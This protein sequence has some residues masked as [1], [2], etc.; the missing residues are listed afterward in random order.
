M[1]NH[2][3][4]MLSLLLLPAMTLA[5]G[6]G[7]IAETTGSVSASTPTKTPRPTFTPDARVAQAAASPTVTATLTPSPTIEIPTATPPPPPSDTP[8]VPP[9]PTL[10]PTFTPT[11]EPTATPMLFTPTP[12]AIFVEPDEPDIAKY[13]FKIKQQGIIPVNENGGKGPTALTNVFIEVEDSMQ[14]PLNGIV[15]QDTLSGEEVVTGGDK[16]DGRAEILMQGRTLVIK[17]V[18]DANTGRTYASEETHRLSVAEPELEDLVAPGYCESVETCE[19]NPY[20]W[21]FSYRIVFQRQW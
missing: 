10:E 5:S 6:C 15:L 4:L 1:I 2:K 21:H 12:P 18:R 9:P 14:N 8:T 11:P 13:D 20:M 19:Y 17:A 16:G 3:V 7:D